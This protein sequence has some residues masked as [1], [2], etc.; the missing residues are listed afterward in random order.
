SGQ[1]Y[2]GAKRGYLY[3]AAEVG[4]LAARFLIHNDAEDTRDAYREEVRQNVVFDGPGT[5]ETWD[6]IEDFEHATLFDN[7]HNVYTDNNGEPLERT[8]AWYWTDR[9]AFKDEQRTVHDSP[10]RLEALARRGDANDKFQLA[11][12]FLGI[13]ILNHVVSAV[14]ARIATKSYNKKYTSQAATPKPFEL[15]LQT[16]FFP[17]TVQSQVVLRKRF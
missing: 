12:T 7:W 2:T 16:T 14:D 15:D 6:P 3:I 13:V 8:G 5:F 9:A 17:D 11:R 10:Q 1:L 4:L